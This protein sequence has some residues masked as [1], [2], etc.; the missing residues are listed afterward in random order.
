MKDY[1]NDLFTSIY[2]LLKNAVVIDGSTVEVGTSIT[3]DA[4][5]FVRYYITSDTDMST[6]D[7]QIRNIE[8]SFECVVRQPMHLGNDE[9]ADTMVDQVKEAILNEDSFIMVDWVL[10]V[11]SDQGTLTDDGEV[12]SYFVNVRTFTANLIIQKT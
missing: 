7:S 12:E 9:D 11:A 2:N 4:S 6:M 3:E 8:V 1:R 10:I 5:H